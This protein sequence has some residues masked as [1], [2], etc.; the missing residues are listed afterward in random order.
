MDVSI[1][2]SFVI[3]GTEVLVRAG[4]TITIVDSDDTL[5]L[6][7]PLQ[8]LDDDRDRELLKEDEDA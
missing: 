8:D 1:P 7:E 6:N 4:E 3:P 2:I 5:G